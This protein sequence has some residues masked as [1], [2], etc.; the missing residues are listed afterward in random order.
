MANTTSYEPRS[1]NDL[2]SYIKTEK[3]IISNIPIIRFLFTNGEFTISQRE[4]TKMR[5]SFR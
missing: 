1:W 2:G 3:G 5:K 4:F